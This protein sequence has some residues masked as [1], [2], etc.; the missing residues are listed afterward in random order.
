ME[1]ADRRSAHLENVKEFAAVIPS[2][3]LLSF[4]NNKATSSPLEAPR[5]S[6]TLGPFLPSSPLTPGVPPSLPIAHL[7]ESI[8]RFSVTLPPTPIL[9]LSLLDRL[10]PGVDSLPA[11]VPYGIDSDG[12]AVFAGSP[13]AYIQQD[14]EAWEN[15]DPLLNQVIGYGAMPE[16]LSQRI[17]RGKFGMDGIYT[18][19]KVCVEELNISE[20]LLEGKTERLIDALLL[21]YVHSLPSITLFHISSRFS[22]GARPGP[23]SVTQPPQAKMIIHEVLEL[24]SPP[25]VSY[26]L[27]LSTFAAQVMA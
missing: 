26:R 18:W 23:T 7:H 16:T 1:S 25:R 27:L 17:Q 14:D 4:V 10:T 19:L 11:E 9:R 24:D 3:T 15:L 13:R 8:T 22:R 20:G 2:K 12:L 21:L 6:S 5:S